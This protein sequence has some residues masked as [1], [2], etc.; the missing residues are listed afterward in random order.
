MPKVPKKSGVSTL[1]SVTE[2]ATSP[3]VETAFK[4]IMT[5]KG[6]YSESNNGHRFLNLT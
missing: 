1:L 2:V 6:C 4:S 3:E 5:E